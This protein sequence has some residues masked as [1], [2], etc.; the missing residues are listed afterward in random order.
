MRVNH[1]PALLL[2]VLLS[3]VAIALSSSTGSLES[4]SLDKRKFTEILNFFKEGPRFGKQSTHSNKLEKFDQAV[5]DID[6]KT[7]EAAGDPKL[8]SLSA[9]KLVIKTAN[10][11]KDPALSQRAKDALAQ[12]LEASA[13]IVSRYTVYAE[14]VHV[15]I[16]KQ[17]SKMPPSVEQK[18]VAENALWLLKQ[19]KDAHKKTLS[20]LVKTA[21]KPPRKQGPPFPGLR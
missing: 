17:A 3:S 7:T 1:H 16:L 11:S 10:K 14:K 12:R 18:Q 4:Q 20:S 21:N 6:A 8:P 13:K 2:L 9:L 15:D 19:S 5:Q